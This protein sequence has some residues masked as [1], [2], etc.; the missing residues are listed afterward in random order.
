M[1][2]YEEIQNALSYIDARDRDTWFEVG[3][4]LKDELGEDGYTLWD[5]WS[6][7]AENY[8]SQDAKSVWKSIK[9]GHIHIA[10]MFHY[11]K[12]GGYKPTKPYVPPTAAE[13]ARRAAE[14]QAIR[15]AEEKAR[16]EKQAAVKS[17][18]QKIWERAKPA[19]L[20]HPYLAAKG[21][22]AASAI[23]GL[24]QN[25]YK[26]DLHLL[27]P[28]IHEREIV[29]LQSINQDGSK[30]FLAGGQV[31]GGYAVVGDASKTENGIEN[32]IVIAEGYATA[33]SIHQATGKPVIVAFNAGNMVTVSERLAKVLPPDVPVVLAVDNDASQTGIKKAAQAA[34]YFGERA[35]AIQP[36]FTMTQIQQYQRE[37][38][39][40][41]DGNPQLPSD[42]NDLHHL[43]GI[44]AVKTAFDGAFR[45]PEMTPAAEAASPRPE[46]SDDM[47]QAIIDEARLRG[48]PLPPQPTTEAAEQAAS[49]QPEI[50]MSE[51]SEFNCAEFT[52]SLRDELEKEARTT[53][54]WR[55]G[56]FAKADGSYL[57]ADSAHQRIGLTLNIDRE[58]NE[59]VVDLH[60]LMANHSDKQRF[61]IDGS[62]SVQEI[63]NEL[64]QAAKRMSNGLE[65]PTEAALRPA[66]SIEYD[67]VNQE[68]A[69]ANKTEVGG[70][71]PQP[72]ERPQAEA[73]PQAEPEPAGEPTGKKPSEAEQRPLP[74]LDLNYKIPPDSIKSRYI[75]ADG[76]Y[77]SAQN[78]TTV[79][80]EDKGKYIATAKTDTQTINDMLEVAKA[81]GW[82]SIKLNG[83]K[84]F[85]QMMYVA[86]ESQGIRTKGYAPTP[87]DLA[88]V[89]HLRQDKSLNSIEAAPAR[90]PEI[91]TPIEPA[92]QAAPSTGD[93]IVAHG[94]APYRNDPQQQESYYLT[95]AKDGKERTVW[96][97]GLPAALEK[98]GAQVGDSINLH[99]L[100]KQPV[101]IQAPVHDADGKVVGHETKQTNRNVFEIEVLNRQTAPGQEDKLEAKQETAAAIESKPEY[102]RKI[103]TQP[104]V[105]A[106]SAAE[107][108]LAQGSL[109]SEA[110][111]NVS[112]RADTDKNVPI[113]AI[114]GEE[115]HAEVKHHA[116]DLK[117]EALDTGLV[118]AKQSYMQKAEKLSKPNRDRLAFYERSTLDAIRGARDDV[119]TEAMRNYYEHAAKHM[120]GSKLSLPP[121]VQIPNQSQSATMQ[122]RPER[123]QSQQ[124]SRDMA[125]PEYGR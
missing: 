116:D 122:Q 9:P 39:L 53:G 22:T 2:N 78:G 81:K 8:K 60:S 40:D 88:L 70:E 83:T 62:R 27:V 112:E 89:E 92:V 68:R 84:E 67:G 19:D 11:A 123:S 47:A 118:S 93:R 66:N 14:S 76:Q 111:I 113:H 28:V 45:R 31:K 41:S 43:A 42:F 101:E 97:I 73:K 46:I 20:N 18:A 54:F 49:S 34:A 106:L 80:F 94:A 87:A 37:K 48:M 74:V 114:G 102:E 120:S 58:K 108:L 115:I 57:R 69:P 26:G 105:A 25:P 6:Q 65:V 17:N 72:G 52:L 91:D 77:L 82:D 107:K 96:G 119:R 55:S 125:E 75:V 56:V 59:S 109:P 86:A 100:G 21:I 32:G 99:S 50:I 30:R 13:Q 79:L 110:Q 1:S 5:N 71:T 3:A 85:K 64:S 24:R 29:N 117:A 33:A 44:D 90:T 16:A 12:A 104:D 35:Q 36:E 23:V 63:A 15:Q 4:A 38:G 121:P 10:S 61:R 103:Q 124:P 7:S 95:L 51:K 98:S